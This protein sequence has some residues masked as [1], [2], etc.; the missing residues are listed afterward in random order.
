MFNNSGKLV[1]KENNR[2]QP[3]YS[4]TYRRGGLNQTSKKLTYDII[5]NLVKDRDLLIEIDSS[6]FSLSYPGAKEKFFEEL[7]AELRDL[8]IEYKY[9]KHS[10]S[11]KRKIFGLSI[12]LSQTENEHELLIYVPNRTWVRDG[13]WKL[14]PEQGATYRVLKGEINGPEFL[15]DI[16]AGRLLDKEIQKHYEIII[17]DYYNFGQMGIDTDLSKGELKELLQGLVESE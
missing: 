2:I 8:K 7:V 9:R 12:S 14:L 6:L 3:R 15:D 4:L 17:F 11:Q 13:F 5:S 16:F 1:L 10:S